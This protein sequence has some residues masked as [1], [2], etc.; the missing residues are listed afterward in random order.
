MK[1]ITSLLTI[2]LGAF[3]MQAQTV[4]LSENFTTYMGTAGTVP[5]GW[6]FSYNGNYTTTASSGTSGPNS[7]KFGVNNATITAPTFTN[8]DTLS[9]WVKGNGTDSLS[10]LI[11]VESPDNVT[12]DTIAKVYDLPINLTGQT[13][14]FGMQNTS[15]YVRFIYKKSV[16]NAAFDDFKL[17]QNPPPPPFI[18][19]FTTT[20]VCFGTAASFSDA[21]VSNAGTVNS[22]S[23]NFGD[24]T[25]IN[26]TQNPTHLYSTAGTFNVTL[27]SGDNLSNLDTTTSMI[28]VDSVVS[29]LS[30]SLAGSVA[31]FSGF[32]SNGFTP[33]SYLL[34]IDDGS[35]FF[36]TTPNYVYT[37]PSPGI[38]TACLISYDNM[39]C[40]DTTC[41]TFTILSTGINNVTALEFK[42]S[43]NPSSTGLFNLEIGNTS[44][45]TIVTVFNIIGKTV[46]TKEITSSS[47]Q[48][49][50]LSNQANGSYF[51]RIQNDT[52]TI[53]KKIVVNK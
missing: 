36:I 42:I 9:F 41:T 4:I 22:W 21:S 16:G 26:T 27:I 32:G 20:N 50:D 51:V 19:A 2:L 28:I 48:L 30:V 40:F 44:N 10:H 23:W 45:N 5:V 25:P 31:T 49:L 46:L 34:D 37:Y 38:Y 39:G 29:N 35:G 11:V 17:I 7:Y 3:S 47:R 14:K 53:V 13:F 12:W 43:P 24:G 15:Q 8:A 52:E 33:Y 6:T 18:A 1:K